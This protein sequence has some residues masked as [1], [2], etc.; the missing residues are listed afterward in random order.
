MRLS[1]LPLSFLGQFILFCF[2]FQ[3]VYDTG[4][5]YALNLPFMSHDS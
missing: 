3:L 1:L 5:E 2:D 4:N